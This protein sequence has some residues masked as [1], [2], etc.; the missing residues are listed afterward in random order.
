MTSAQWTAS[1]PQRANGQETC[2]V[3]AYAPFFASSSCTTDCAPCHAC[4]VILIQLGCDVITEIQP[5]SAA[6]INVIQQFERDAGALPGSLRLGLVRYGLERNIKIDL[7]LLDDINEFTNVVNGVLIANIE[8]MK[9]ITNAHPIPALQQ[10]LQLFQDYEEHRD[11]TTQEPCKDKWIW[12]ITN[13]HLQCSE[14]ICYPELAAPFG[15]N[16]LP[17]FDKVENLLTGL[18]SDKKLRQFLKWIEHPEKKRTFN[19]IC[20]DYMTELK[21]GCCLGG[22]CN[23]SHDRNNRCSQVQFDRFNCE[24]NRNVRNEFIA[25]IANP[26]TCFTVNSQTKLCITRSKVLAQFELDLLRCDHQNKQVS[27]MATTVNRAQC[28]YSTHSFSGRSRRIWTESRFEDCHNA[29]MLEYLNNWNNDHAI[30]EV[31]CQD[32]DVLCSTPTLQ[33][34][35]CQEYNRAIAGGNALHVEDNSYNTVAECILQSAEECEDRHCDKTDCD[36]NFFFPQPKQREVNPD[37]GCDGSRGPVGRNGPHG[38]TGA[39]GLPG[40]QGPAGGQGNCGARGQRGQPGDAAGPIAVPYQASGEKGLPG[41]P[42]QPGTHGPQGRPG[43]QGPTGPRGKPGLRGGQGPNGRCG[44]TGPSGSAG[45]PGSAGPQGPQGSTGAA[46][47]GIED[48]S[49]Y[50]E[51]KAM[52][53]VELEALVSSVTY[54][55]GRFSGDEL[56][57]LIVRQMSA[58]MANQLNIVCAPGYEAYGSN[59][60]CKSPRNSNFAPVSNVQPTCSGSNNH[61]WDQNSTQQP[62]TEPRPRPTYAPIRTIPATEPEVATLPATEP[63]TAQPESFATTASG[64]SGSGYSEA[65]TEDAFWGSDSSSGSESTTEADDSDTWRFSGWGAKRAAPVLTKRER[66]NSIISDDDQLTKRKSS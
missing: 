32:G 34:A 48:E 29:E 44:P 61:W 24:D 43:P 49:Y 30:C 18:V 4:A 35:Q 6:V 13:G 1:R 23:F 38:G 45:S 47:R 50:R 12:Y 14:C 63:I 2:D 27:I 60:Q 58:V 52:L 5:I 8:D 56:A 17:Q 46:G 65:S 3:E 66:Q 42:G 57:V 53:R 22:N 16:Q 54:V 64:S 41:P 59:K 20:S 33:P 51:Y 7:T 15:N 39:S 19:D 31:L 21:A 40:A 9:P 25:L 37:S 26:Q 55:N 10:T 11:Q 36:V 62:V 28:Q